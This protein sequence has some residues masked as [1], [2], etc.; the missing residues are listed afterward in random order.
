MEKLKPQCWRV[1]LMSDDAIKVAIRE[2]E[3]TDTQKQ[4]RSA[5]QRIAP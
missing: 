1:T 3:T 2:V 5:A 4:R